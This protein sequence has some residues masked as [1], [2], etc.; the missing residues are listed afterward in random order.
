MK[1]KIWIIRPINGTE[2]KWI[3]SA[4]IKLGPIDI[5]QKV[6]PEYGQCS[7][8]LVGNLSAEI[9]LEDEDAMYQK[10]AEII[11]ELATLRD[12]T[13]CDEESHRDCGCQRFDLLID[14]I[15]QL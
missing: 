14:K 1:K 4:P 12:E 2:A 13:P 10:K 6:E 5:L 7:I 11:A 15:S 9:L 3:I 8:E